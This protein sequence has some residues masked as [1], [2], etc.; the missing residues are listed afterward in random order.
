MRL[1]A[2]IGAPTTEKHIVGRLLGAK[3]RSPVLSVSALLQ[4]E[5][6]HRTFLGERLAEERA[7]ARPGELLPTKLV[8]PLLMQSLQSAQRAGTASAVLVGAPRSLEQW[9][10]LRNAGMA[11]ELIHLVLP[12]ARQAHRYGSRRVCAGCSYP[13]YP[14]EDA[15][16]AGNSS[17]LGCGCNDGA[18]H[19]LPQLPLDAT[20]PGLERRKAEW[21]T[22]TA[23]MLERLRERGS[24][25]HEIKVLEDLEHTWASVMVALDI[26]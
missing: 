10:M 3:L 8:A 2:V 23:P 14:A 18:P 1:L 20:G 9:S 17:L 24:G 5:V 22:H 21:D 4:N 7:A 12:D 19:P 13:L 16:K 6:Q 15:S 25:L 11:P 26:E